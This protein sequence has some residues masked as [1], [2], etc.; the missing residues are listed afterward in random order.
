MPNQLEI[1]ADICKYPDMVQFLAKPGDQIL[2]SFTPEKCN[3]LHAGVG[4]ASEGGEILDVIKKHVIYNQQLDIGHLVEELG[5]ME[6]FMEQ[7]RAAI[8]ISRDYI[9][10]QNYEKLMNKR[11]P[12]GYSDE[13]A[14]ERAD[15]QEN[16]PWTHLNWRNVIPGRKVMNENGNVFTIVRHDGDLDDGLFWMVDAEGNKHIGCVSDGYDVQ[17]K[18]GHYIHEPSQE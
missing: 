15:K 11:Y 16:I 7:A 5:D 17:V 9:L 1:W 3:L 14:Q 6:F 13:A 18:R 8:G 12:N 2:A 4:I 10:K